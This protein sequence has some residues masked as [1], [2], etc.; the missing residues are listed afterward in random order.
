MLIANGPPHAPVGVHVPSPTHSIR[1]VLLLSA[2]NQ[3]RGIAARAVIAGM[4]NQQTGWNRFA[5]CQLPRDVVSLS[6]LPCYL[7]GTVAAATGA[8]QPRPAFQWG[9]AVYLGPEPGREC[10]IL[11][12][13]FRP[14]LSHPCAEISAKRQIIDYRTPRI[15]C[16]FCTHDSE[17]SFKVGRLGRIR[18]RKPL[19]RHLALL[20]N[21]Q[22]FDEGPERAA[23]SES[24]SF[25][26]VHVQ[27]VGEFGIGHARGLHK[28]RDTVESLVVVRFRHDEGSMA[29]EIAQ[30][31]H[32]I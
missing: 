6:M 22:G 10:G 5:I 31:K 21:L 32:K 1:D 20:G 9:F 14:I 3:V 11:R 27:I 29:D 28:L 30:C 15:L 4:T 2:R 7:E 17:R 19:N 13:C 24:D 26:A 8:R 12:A 16:S 23:L 18:R 25:R